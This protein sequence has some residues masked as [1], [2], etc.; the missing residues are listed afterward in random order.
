[1]TQIKTLEDYY[2]H[3]IKRI[4]VCWIVWCK[5]HKKFHPKD[6]FRFRD[7]VRHR[8]PECKIWENEQRREREKK[9]R[10]REKEMR[11]RI[12]NSPLQRYLC[13]KW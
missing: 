9:Q 12:R 2:K 5:Q 3:E 7:D 10:A 1:V 4:H 8:K 13:C 6:V 11:Q